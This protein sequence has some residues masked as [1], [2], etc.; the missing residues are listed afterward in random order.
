M[1]DELNGKTA[2]I[3]SGGAGQPILILDSDDVGALGL[4]LPYAWAAQTPQAA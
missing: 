3:D 4:V 2:N 1:V